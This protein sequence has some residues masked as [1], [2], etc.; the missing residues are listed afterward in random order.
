MAEGEVWG[1]MLTERGVAQG[2]GAALMLLL[3]CPGKKNVGS[4][5]RGPADCTL[6]AGVV[7]IFCL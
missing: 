2:R 1:R 4:P 6:Q 3:L 7:L 5:P